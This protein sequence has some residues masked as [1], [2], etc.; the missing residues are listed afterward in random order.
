[1]LYSSCSELYV[2]KGD[3]IESGVVIGK[4]GK[5]GMSTG[6]RLHIEMKLN[7]Q[8]INPEKYINF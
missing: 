4:V 3:N 8:S 5:T 2:N 1:M 7:N 6:N